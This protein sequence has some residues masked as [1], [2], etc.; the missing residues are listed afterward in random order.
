MARATTKGICSFCQATFSKATIG[1][2]LAACPK[3]AEEARALSAEE[4]VPVFHIV[5]DGCDNPMYWMHLSVPVEATLANLDEFFRDIWV[6]C[7]EHLSNFELSGATYAS[8]PDEEFGDESMEIQVGDLLSPGQEFSYEYDY[9]STT[10]LRLRVLSQAEEA[11]EDE[12][13]KILARNEAPHMP[14][15][16]CGRAAEW[17][18]SQCV[19]SEDGA[20]FCEKC[21]KSHACGDDFLLPVV[22]SPRVGTCAYEG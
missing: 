22:N 14:C 19:Y 11:R 20:W 18:C 15:D 9:G 13:I 16:A 3:R 1:R 5:V 17:V 4:K 21:S 2:H 8:S 10:E 7:C 12:S 6:E